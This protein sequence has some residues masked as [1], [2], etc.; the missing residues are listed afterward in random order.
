MNW[1]EKLEKQGDPYSQHGESKYI[2]QILGNIYGNN[3][4]TFI[5]IGAGGDLSNTQYFIDRGWTG[6][7]LDKTTG[8]FVTAENILQY[9]EF[10]RPVE[11]LS[12]DIDGNDYWVLFEVLRWISPTLIVAEFNAHYT[13]SRV[14]KYNPKHEWDGT[15]YYGF[16]FEAGLRLAERFGYR[17]IFQNDNLN[18]YFVRKHLIEVDI[19]EIKYE[20]INAFP[21]REGEWVYVK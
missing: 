17:V 2:E 3:Q 12:I 18:M 19:P 4:K 16:T 15:S 9:L 6:I 10:D 11:L 5:D 20:K 13:D 1:I 8:Q 21:E 14:M 7:S